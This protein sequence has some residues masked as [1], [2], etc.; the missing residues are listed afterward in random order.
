MKNK[1]QIY[2]SESPGQTKKM[3]KL[4]ARKILGEKS[5]AAARVLALFGDLGAGKTNFVQGFAAGLGIKETINSPTFTILKKYSLP[6][7][8][9]ENFYH[10][11]FYRLGAEDDLELLGI[12]K[13]LNDKNNIVAIEWPQVAA[14]FLPQSARAISFEI[15]GA[16][17]RRLLAEF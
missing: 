13:I 8:G 9:R 16:K 5:G 14:E 7:N 1:K 4:L 17:T 11:D 12:K 15:A 6:G 2:I 3:G 10:I